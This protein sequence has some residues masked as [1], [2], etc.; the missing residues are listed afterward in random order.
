MSPTIPLAI[1]AVAL[2]FKVN[3]GLVTLGL[4]GLTDGE[5]WQRPGGGNPIAWV[6]GHMTYS[7]AQLLGLIGTPWE[8][9]LGRMFRRGVQIQD[10]SAYPSRAAIEAAWKA[11]HR[12]MRDGFATLTEAQLAAPVSGP[13]LP[14]AKTL[15]D[16][17]AFLALHESYHVGQISYVRRLLGRSTIADV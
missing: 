6:L 5:M 2:I 1:E 15:T 8:P 3:N 7:R 12:R 14:G 11:S 16:Q 4:E 17:I 13:S 10:A 9:G